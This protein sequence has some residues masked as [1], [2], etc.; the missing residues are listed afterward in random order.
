V[1]ISSYSDAVKYFGTEGLDSYTIPAA[2]RAIFDQGGAMAIVVNV[3][4]PTANNANVSA[5]SV[6]LNATTDKGQLAHAGVTS[7]VFRSAT[8][9][10]TNGTFASDTGWTKGSG[11]T[12]A[13]G[14]AS[15]DG[16]QVAASDLAQNQACTEGRT[17]AVTY[18]ITRS[19]G[20][21]TPKIG[22][23]A[24]TARATAGTFTDVIICGAGV[25]PK[26]EFEADADF[27]GTV[28]TVDCREQFILTT[29]YLLDVITGGITRVRTGN[30]ASGASLK[31]NYSW[32]DPSAIVA[33][34]IVG[35]ITAGVRSGAQCWLDAANLLGI[36]PKILIA[37]GYASSAT[38]IAGLEVL[39]DS[40]RAVYI[41]D[42]AS[43]TTLPNALLTRAY[44]GVFNT[45]SVRGIACYPY[46][47]DTDGVLRPFSQYLAGV[48]SNQ[49]SVNG[50]WFS[51]S[52]VEIVGVSSLERALS[53]QLNDPNCD[54]NTLNANGF[55]TAATGYGLGIRSWGNRNLSY[56][57]STLPQNF[58]AV[59][60]VQDVL[61]DSVEYA[62][63]QFMDQP[64]N[65]A[66][67]DSIRATVN[68]YI[69]TLIGRGALIDGSCTFDKAKNPDVEMA[70]GHL[71]FDLTFLPPFPAERITF[72][73]Y[74][75]IN[76]FRGL[77]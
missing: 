39:A 64:I 1:L 22:G 28:D 19:A 46:L 52:N 57:T 16:T 45:S 5:E 63:L 41:A 30:I 56:P 24:G 50:F 4:D 26:L 69:R 68:A 25:D 53:F 2:L 48:I 76:L 20:T 33:A 54:T 75:D 66:L 27:V 34:D 74:I 21:I 55:V 12:I 65:Q 51:P 37:P 3:L 38:T 15:C 17:Y 58:I 18:T 10:T 60:R 44:G 61:W 11:W 13:A 67:I 9:L 40:L 35:T 62:T 71:T 77:K 47:N 73:S 70:A 43:G 42:V 49:D 23:T 32:M 31:V 29:D 72:N 8:D 14:V 7:G 36:K 59:L 6:T